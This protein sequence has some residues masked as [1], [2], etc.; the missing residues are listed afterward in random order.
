MPDTI[1]ELLATEAALNKLGARDISVVEVEQVPRN[2]HAVVCNPR[3]KGTTGLRR[4]L[5]GRTDGGRCLTIV[6]QRTVDPT[7]WM[8]VSGWNSTET[9][10]RILSR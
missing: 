3:D 8:I 1:H 4:L 9:E 10:R 7:T 6:I 2:R 5:I